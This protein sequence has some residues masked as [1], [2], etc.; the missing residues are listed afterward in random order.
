MT[1]NTLYLAS[2]LD[3]HCIFHC[4]VFISSPSLSE[5][6]DC[7]ISSS[8]L[9][10]SVLCFFSQNL[11]STSGFLLVVQE[12]SIISVRRLLV[13][14]SKQNQPQGPV[15]VDVT[16]EGLHQ[17]SVFPI[18]GGMGILD[19]SVAYRA[20]IAVDVAASASPT[21]VYM[22]A[23]VYLS[24]KINRCTVRTIVIWLQLLNQYEWRQVQPIF[25]TPTQRHH[26]IMSPAHI[27]FN[28]H[29][30]QTLFTCRLGFTIDMYMVCSWDRIHI[31]GKRGSIRAK[32]ACNCALKYI[33]DQ[34]I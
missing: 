1:I 24:I 31:N 3:K 20:D 29:M 21:G 12:K 33:Q 16:E 7:D 17:V 14:T 22:H 34:P 11:S 27:N 6:D 28:I 25:F 18:R 8:D 23:G 4:V 5:I 2:K 26:I 32:R 30:H 9:T 15:T 13:N 19:S 10:V